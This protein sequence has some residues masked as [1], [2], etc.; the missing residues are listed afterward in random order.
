MFEIQVLGDL[1]LIPRALEEYNAIKVKRLDRESKERELRNMNDNIGPSGHQKLQVCDVCGAYLS[2]LDNDRRL[3]D[4][5]AGKMHLGYATMRALYKDLQEKFAAKG[6]LPS[7]PSN[8]S[9][10]SRDGR[11]Y[12]EGHRSDRGGPSRDDRWSRGGRN[13]VYRSGGG[14]GR[15][16][17]Y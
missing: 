5:F 6:T 14:D 11:D 4:H 8:G 13:G 9:R 2:R 16:G 15:R 7:G 12:S 3:A 17:R 1:G 10:G